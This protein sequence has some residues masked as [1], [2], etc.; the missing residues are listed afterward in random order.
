MYDRKS[1]FTLTNDYVLET[2]GVRSAPYVLWTIFAGLIFSTPGAR[3]NAF[4][5]RTA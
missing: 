2:P 5:C 1:P 3:A 4:Y